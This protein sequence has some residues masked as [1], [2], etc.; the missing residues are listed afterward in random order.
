V[1]AG[2]FEERI[3]ECGLAMVNMR[4][5]RNIPYIFFVFFDSA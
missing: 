4:Y 1:G 2:L 3:D 5:N